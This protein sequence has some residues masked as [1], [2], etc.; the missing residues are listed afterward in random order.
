MRWW[1]SFRLILLYI[2]FIPFSAWSSEEAPSFSS[3]PQF[4]VSSSLLSLFLVLGVIIGLAWI[5]KKMKH[6]PFSHQ[7]ELCIVRQ[8]PIGT[9]E[10][11]A[12]IKAG[13]EQFLVGIT[14]QSIQLISKLDTPLESTLPESN[15]SDASAA[16]NNTFATKL[17]EVLKKR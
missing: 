9:K 11:I 14:P 8:I 15:S 10:R 5:V 6:S 3:N 4:D 2:V 1:L 13:E 12:V 7:S 17:A 16:L